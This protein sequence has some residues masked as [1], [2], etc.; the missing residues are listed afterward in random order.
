MELLRIS[1]LWQ[2]ANICFF[3]I[4]ASITVKDWLSFRFFQILSCFWTTVGYPR[5]KKEYLLTTLRMGFY[6]LR[7]FKIKPF[8][9]LRGL[10]KSFK[11]FLTPPAPDATVAALYPLENLYL[12]SARQIFACL[13]FT[14]INIPGKFSQQNYKILYKFS[15][16][17]SDLSFRQQLVALQS[18]RQP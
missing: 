10:H 18:S 1:T 8:Y 2:F 16:A 3:S 12:E 9:S 11:P 17:Q 13:L 4:R 14:L 15:R 5:G 6:G 7:A